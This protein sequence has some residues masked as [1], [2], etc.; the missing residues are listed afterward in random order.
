MKKKQTESKK[1]EA[2]GPKQKTGNVPAVR[3]DPASFDGEAKQLAKLQPSVPIERKA[4][5]EADIVNAFNLM[6]IG[7]KLNGDQMRLFVA[8][9]REWKLNPL[10]RE[11]YAVRMG[12][13]EDDPESKGTLVPVVEYEVYI[14]RAEE[15]RLLEYWIMTDIGEIDRQDWKKST[16][17]A[18]VHIKRRNW[19]K[20]FTWTSRYVEC[21]ALKGGKVPN[22]MWDK[23]GYF[24]TQKCAIGQGFR[25]C[26]REATRG[27]PYIDSEIEYQ[28]LA[29]DERP[30]PIAEPQPITGV[31]VDAQ[32]KILSAPKG[33]GTV[34]PP[35]LRPITEIQ[36][37]MRT[38]YESM[39]QVLD[40]K[41]NL[42]K[43]PQGKPRTALPKEAG[44]PGG[45]FSRL[46]PDDQLDRLAQT[47]TAEKDPVK[48]ESMLADWRVSL[49]NRYAEIGF[50]LAGK[51]E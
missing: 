39:Q 22:R 46:F 48:L 9:C 28:P 12:A 13:D 30:A 8:I 42:M 36:A 5:E 4:M 26:F 31:K 6:G 40:G 27:L 10:R 23:R 11:I 34:P 47:A 50:E 41:G 38:V 16:Y 37:D 49:Q 21:V 43:D 18:T 29:E 17:A 45:P 14:D 25:L 3:S 35:K 19:S 51:K 15:T 24:M 44:F 32:G 7:A 1:T 33:D 20:E 2:K